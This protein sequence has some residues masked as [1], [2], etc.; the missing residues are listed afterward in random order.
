MLTEVPK[1]GQKTT[2]IRYNQPFEVSWSLAS[3]TLESILE[4]TMRCEERGL[5]GV[6]FPDHEAP[7]ARWP[8]LYVTLSAIAAQT[9]TVR[10]GSLVTDVLRRHPIVT[11][12]A[13]ASLSHMAPG[14]VILGLGAGGGPSQA[15]YGISLDHS[16][17]RLGEGI[18]VI[19]MLLGAREKADFS[20]EYFS[21][22]GAQPPMLPYSEIPVYVASYGPRMLG[23]TAELA[24]GW[25][26]ESHT[27]E[28]Y[29]KTLLDSRKDEA[30]WQEHPRLSCLLRLDL[31]PLGA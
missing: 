2:S 27:P 14:R 19:K 7:L 12:H 28:T 10:F 24:D 9:R 20:G 16:A 11:A 30:L 25:L 31:L 8:E 3:P 23:L 17:G 6:W 15:P 1:Q 4:E 26:P 21:L 18:R 13:F 29:R 22:K 5:D